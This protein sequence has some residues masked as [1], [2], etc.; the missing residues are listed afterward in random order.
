MKTQYLTVF[1]VRSTTSQYR[2]KMTD[3]AQE[4]VG[5]S[6]LAT[7]IRTYLSNRFDFAT[8]TDSGHF[9]RLESVAT[10]SIDLAMT[11]ISY[12]GR[13]LSAEIF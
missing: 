7:N 13:F 10:V 2:R 9:C 12:L 8:S 5:E 4:M 6:T 11:P 3:E 1:K